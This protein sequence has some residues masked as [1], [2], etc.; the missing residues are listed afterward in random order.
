M[1]GEER[2]PCHGFSAAAA[3]R[4]SKPAAHRMTTHLALPHAAHGKVAMHAGHVG[5]DE[6]LGTLIAGPVLRS[7]RLVATCAGS[8]AQSVLTTRGVVLAASYRRYGILPRRLIMRPA[9]LWQG[10]GVLHHAAAV[11]LAWPRRPIVLGHPPLPGRSA[12]GRLM[13][14][15]LPFSRGG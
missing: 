7:M 12:H 10:L 1:E 15:C 14:A 9:P 6:F 8:T 3:V 5:V 4:G 13:S 2:H 11:T